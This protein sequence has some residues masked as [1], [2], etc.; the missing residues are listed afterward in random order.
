MGRLGVVV[1]TTEVLSILRS[2]VTSYEFRHLGPVREHRV[3]SLV[4]ESSQTLMVAVTAG[5]IQLRRAQEPR[6]RL[7]N[8]QRFSRRIQVGGLTRMTLEAERSASI[9]TVLVI[10]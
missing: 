3:T 10:A 9:F 1:D 5:V 2:R 6:A 8:Q 7:S 4:T